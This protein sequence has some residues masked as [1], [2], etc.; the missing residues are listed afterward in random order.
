MASGFHQR[1]TDEIKMYRAM[2][3]IL[4]NPLCDEKTRAGVLPLFLDRIR[5]L[6]VDA[7][8]GGT[9]GGRT[10]AAIALLAGDIEAE[11]ALLDRLEQMDTP[12]SPLRSTTALPLLVRPAAWP[13]GQDGIARWTRWTRLFFPYPTQGT[14]GKGMAPADVPRP[15]RL[16]VHPA[17][18]LWTMALDA[19]AEG[20][21]HLGRALLDDLDRFPK[22]QR[23]PSWPTGLRELIDRDIP[24]GP[25]RAL[26]D[27]LAQESLETAADS[28]HAGAHSGV[29]GLALALRL[30]PDQAVAILE[31]AAKPT[32]SRNAQVR[33]ERAI[34]HKVA[35]ALSSAHARMAL[36]TD[37][38]RWDPVA[39]LRAKHGKH[40]KVAL[41]LM[42]V[43]HDPAQDRRERQIAAQAARGRT[44]GPKGGTRPPTHT[45]L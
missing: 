6:H 14:N 22:G 34:H 16:L 43:A 26:L 30:R 32:G 17:T 33:G 40:T 36:F 27:A 45:A 23:A 7:L 28:Q 35:Q 24:P 39:L 29:V 20:K 41:R 44:K 15:T 4:A 19:Y 42:G 2:A 13:D 1:R 9:A 8:L 5:T 11:D 10:G 38:W 31:G 37:A 12:E 25:T 21:P 18:P 3:D